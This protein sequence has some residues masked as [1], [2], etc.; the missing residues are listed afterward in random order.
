M[1]YYHTLIITKD[2]KVERVKDLSE[3][4]LVEKIVKP[5]E[6]AGI[7]FINGTSINSIE[8]GRIH[9]RQTVETYNSISERLYAEEAQRRKENTS[10][11]DLTPYTSYDDSF[12]TGVDVLDKFIKGPV[13]YK[14]EKT[15]RELSQIDDRSNK[16]FI[17]H[18]HN[19]EMKQTTARFLESFGL[20]PVILHDEPNQG[21]T[22]I[23][24]FSDYSDVRY[25]VILLSADD[26]AYT[27]ND[28]PEN[29]KHRAR[30]NVILE[31]GY[32]LGRLGRDKVAAIY[33]KAQEIEIPSDF[34]GVLYIEYSGNDSWKLPLA[35]ELKATGFE[36][37]MNKMI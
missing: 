17:V 27:K 7:I 26:L 22:I 32:F 8:I 15:K 23:E 30:Q 4:D 9:I 35:R 14:V 13:G 11:F 33:E 19:E 21:R 37:D 24:K 29:A 28:K 36:I 6:Q 25:A 18:G 12:W 31:L 2:D 10:Y 3:S 1:E 5:Y 20:H 16:I 34:S